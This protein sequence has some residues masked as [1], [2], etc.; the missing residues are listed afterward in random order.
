MATSFDNP[1]SINDGFG[2]L[3]DQLQDLIS[4]ASK[5]Q[6]NQAL[7]DAADQIVEDAHKLP[8]PI[9]RI[10]KA[11][12]THLVNSITSSESSRSSGVPERVI[13][14][15]KFYGRMVEHG[16]QKYSSRAHLIPMYERNKDQYYRIIEHDLGYEK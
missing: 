8:Y 5:E 2:E 1:V 4:N 12:Y 16:T 15:G 10:T 11:G 6:I 9:S 3:Q 13:G 14:W 7:K